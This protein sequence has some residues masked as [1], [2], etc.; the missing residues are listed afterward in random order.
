MGEVQVNIAPF[1][2]QLADLVAFSAKP[3]EPETILRP[4]QPFGFQATVE[5]G[6]SGAIALMPLELTIRLDFYAKAVGSGAAIDLGNTSLKTTAGQFIY[7]PTLKLSKSAAKTNL[8]PPD[9]YRICAVLRAG[10]VEGPFLVTGVIETL[11]IE[12]CR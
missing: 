1:H 5:F 3:E 9:L 6:G 8:I 10:A 2:C 12:M 4:D 7:T 11:T